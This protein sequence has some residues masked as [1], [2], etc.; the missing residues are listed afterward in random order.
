MGATRISHPRFKRAGTPARMELTDD[1]IAILRCIYRHRFVRADDLYRLFDNRSQDKLSRRLMLLF[2]NEFL[3]RPIAQ[4]DR[5]R[6]GG[7]QA[8]VYGL[9]N[10]GARYLKDVV[11][12]PVGKTD[13]RSRNRT[14]ARENLDHTLAVARFMIDLEIECRARADLELIRFE[15]IVATSPDA[16]KRSV[17]PGSWPVPMQWNGVRSS[18]HIA[19]D[20]IFGLRFMCGD[21][22]KLRSYFFVEIDRGTMTIVPTERV[23]ESEAFPYRATILRKLYAYADS[24]RLRLHEKQFGMKAARIIFLTP[25]KARMEAMRAAAETHTP[26]AAG[27]FLF[28]TSDGQCPLLASLIECS[29]AVCRMLPAARPDNVQAV[30]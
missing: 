28:G 17:N 19:P 5:Y 30:P 25:S 14:Y 3:D 16:T 18:V 21:G 29:G 13:W 2:R 11:G 15:E 7:S 20:A 4:V 24:R 23:R 12:M 26:G 8:I 22:R 27:I 9:G 6:E 1:D 10:A